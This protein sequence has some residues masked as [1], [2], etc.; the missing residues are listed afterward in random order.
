MK[1]KTTKPTVRVQFTAEEQTT[2]LHAAKRAAVALAEYWDALRKAE[3]FHGCEIE[4]GQC[5]A[6]STLAGDCGIPPSIKDLQ[7]YT[8][9][10]LIGQLTI[11]KSAA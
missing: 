11:T 6:I 3:V 5:D 7:G 1:R 10:D 9:E 4:G 8:F 2:I